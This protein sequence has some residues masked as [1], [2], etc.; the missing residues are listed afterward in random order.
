VRAEK[1]GSSSSTH[2]IP[3]LTAVENVM[4]AAILPQHDGRGRALGLW[5]K[6]GLKD[7]AHHLPPSF[8][9]RAAARLLARALINDPKLSWPMSQQATWMPQR[10]NRHAALARIA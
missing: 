6:V 9:R 4:L 7:R 2:M 5:R 8:R 10:G 1:I 3:Y